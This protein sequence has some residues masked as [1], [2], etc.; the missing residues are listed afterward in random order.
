M[1]IKITNDFKNAFRIVPQEEANLFIKTSYSMINLFTKLDNLLVPENEYEGEVEDG[2]QYGYFQL[3]IIEDEVLAGIDEQA[4]ERLGQLS[5][6]YFIGRGSNGVR[7]ELACK[8]TLAVIAMLD[9]IVEEYLPMQEDQMVELREQVQNILRNIV[10]PFLKELGIIDSMRWITIGHQTL[11]VNQ[12]LNNFFIQN[13][14]DV[15]TEC[16]RL[17]DLVAQYPLI[18]DVMEVMPEVWDDFI[19]SVPQEYVGSLL[20]YASAVRVTDIKQFNEGNLAIDEDYM[21][22]LEKRMLREELEDV[23]GDI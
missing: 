10:F 9:D 14:I 8:K 7:I 16:K 2:M 15:E 4:V 18:L 21:N 13:G 12:Y 23:E 20:E 5:G 17:N 1:Q 11:Q 3:A 6:E 19:G 22:I